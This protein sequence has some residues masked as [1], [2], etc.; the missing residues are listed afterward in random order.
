M[1]VIS[2]KEPEINLMIVMTLEVCGL[3]CLV[4]FRY[5][6]TVFIAKC[7]HFI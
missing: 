3:P 4:C 5:D 1:S 7:A 6:E 2:V